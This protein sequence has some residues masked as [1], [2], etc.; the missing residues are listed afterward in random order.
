MAFA[1]LLA[2]CD[3]PREGAKQGLP[4]VTVNQP[5]QQEVTDYVELTGTV[6]PSRSVDLVARV[7]GYLESVEFEDGAMVPEGKVLFVIEPEP[8]KQQ[9]LLAEAAHERAKSEYKRQ[10]SLI[11][12]NATSVANV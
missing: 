5:A 8:Y 4:S 1:L 11:A 7:T 10:V 2:G 6:T 3:K 9:L 12:S